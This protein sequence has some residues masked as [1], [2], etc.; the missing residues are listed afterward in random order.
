MDAHVKFDGGIAEIEQRD[1]QYENFLLNEYLYPADEEDEL[2]DMDWDFFDFGV[3]V[4]VDI[5]DDKALLFVFDNDE[6]IAVANIFS[7][8]D[9][10]GDEVFFYWDFANYWSCAIG[11]TSVQDLMDF[12]QIN[13]IK[14]SYCCPE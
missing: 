9:R 13:D 8:I 4:G 1:E 6:E 14:Y 11:S 10:V 12:C 7:S 5:D 2:E 3:L